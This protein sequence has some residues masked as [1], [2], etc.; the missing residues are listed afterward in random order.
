MVTRASGITLWFT[1]LSGAGKTTLARGLESW[2]NRHFIPVEVLDGDEIRKIFPGRLGFNREDRDI[3]VIR[4]GQIAKL[5]MRHG[6]VSI[7]AAI[8]PYRDTRDYV[9]QD[10]KQFLEIYCECPLSILEKRDRKALY[11]RAR[12]G[13]LTDVTGIDSPYEPPE[14]P[15]LILH[16]GVETVSESLDKVLALLLSVSE[17][18]SRFQGHSITQVRTINMYPSQSK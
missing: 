10:L 4:I 2:L 9:R 18:R 1:G 12:R 11:D 3:Q 7:V 16:T 8:S 13:Q 5:L 14:K 6:I 17:Q 15:D